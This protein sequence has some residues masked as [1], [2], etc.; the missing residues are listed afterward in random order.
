MDAALRI[1]PVEDRASLERFIRLPWSLYVKDRNWVPPLRLE[2][3]THLSPKANPY[4]QDAE[5]KFWLA[6]RGSRNVG[7]ISAQVNHAHLRR[8]QDATGHF[9]F[10]E[11]EDERETFHA[12]LS[13]AEQWLCQQGMRRVLGPFSFSINDECGLL[14]S[15]F[16]TPPYMMMGHAQP[17]YARRLEEQGYV[18]AKDLVAYEYETNRPLPARVE[19]LAQRVRTSDGVRL[20]RLRKS[21]YEDD[22][23]I[24]VDIF[25]DAW[26]DNWG[27]VPFSQAEMRHLA[28]EMKPLVREDLVCIA[29]V[30]G[31]PAAMAVSL[32][33]LNEAIADL[34]GSLLPFGAVKLLWRLTAGRLKTARVLLM[35]VRKKYRESALGTALAVGVIDAIRRNVLRRGFQRAE[36]SWVLEDNLSMCRMIEALGGRPYKTYRIYEKGLHCEA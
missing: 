25:N 13:A 24:V 12:L 16:D 30:E 11:A 17:F 6:S 2:R 1:E 23:R 9:G 7:R 22:I 19:A 29:E 4:F 20:R 26:S 8:Y 34:D 35:G 36:L 5:V 21:R 31:V 10:L 18:K 15:G 33:N 3:R 14:V 27:F 28:K 32:P